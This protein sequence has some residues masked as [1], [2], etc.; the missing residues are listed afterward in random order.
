MFDVTDTSG[1]LAAVSALQAPVAGPTLLGALQGIM[2][3]AEDRPKLPK[4]VVSA[5]APAMKIKNIS[6]AGLDKLHKIQDDPKLTRSEASQIRKQLKALAP[7]TKTEKQVEDLAGRQLT[8]GQLARYITIGAVLGGGM[9]LVRKGLKAGTGGMIGGLKTLKEHPVRAPLSVAGD[10]I[11]DVTTGAVY[12]GVLPVARR[13]ADI[14][15]ARRGK[16]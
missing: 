11:G 9:G 7:R 13:A 4:A 14:E 1:F 3:T 10:V 15:A 6:G 16:F 12:G 5:S 2:K 8:K